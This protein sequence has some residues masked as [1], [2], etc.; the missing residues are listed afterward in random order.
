M[1]DYFRWYFHN[2]PCS[3]TMANELTLEHLEESTWPIGILVVAQLRR[4]ESILKRTAFIQIINWLRESLEKAKKI[5]LSWAFRK[6][7]LATPPNWAW[8]STASPMTLP[9]PNHSASPQLETPAGRQLDPEITVTQGPS[10]WEATDT[11]D[12]LSAFKSDSV[13]YVLHQ[14]E[15]PSHPAS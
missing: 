2:F 3:N 8:K 9:V 13:C 10:N 14:H 12:T 6:N 5:H 4:T 15:D 7:S 1:C 11:T